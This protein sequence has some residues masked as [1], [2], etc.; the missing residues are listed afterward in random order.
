MK[1]G[2]LAPGERGESSLPAGSSSVLYHEDSHEV[3]H[4]SVPLTGHV[5]D[6]G[7]ELVTHPA[8]STYSPYP[9]PLRAQQSRLGKGS[10]A[11]Q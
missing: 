7:I 11:F 2:R 8:T 4:P 3:G 9:G 10:T 1:E 5:A 6:L